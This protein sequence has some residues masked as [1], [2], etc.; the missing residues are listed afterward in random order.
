MV[1]DVRDEDHVGG[2]VA[3]SQRVPSKAHGSS[4]SE[5]V[6]TMQSKK[7]V[8]FHCTQ[9][10]HRGPTAALKYLKEREKVYGAGESGGRSQDV[11]VLEG[12]FGKWQEV[13]GMDKELT[14]AYQNDR[15]EARDL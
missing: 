6:R 10:Q 12:G 7:T 14:E 8:V 5:L 9:S 13:Y 4:I 11:L 3:T 1:I 2:H 15:L